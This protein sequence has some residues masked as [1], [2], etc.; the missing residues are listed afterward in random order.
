[1][2]AAWKYDG[3]SRQGAREFFANPANVLLLRPVLGR[4]R[5]PDIG[6]LL[7]RVVRWVEGEIEEC[8]DADVAIDGNELFGGNDPTNELLGLTHD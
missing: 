8:G 3:G 2:S 5:H 1:M 7:A 6:V 4:E